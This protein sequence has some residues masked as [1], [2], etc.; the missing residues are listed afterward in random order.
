MHTHRQTYMHII[1]QEA[2]GYCIFKFL[3]MSKKVLSQ[4]YL[5]NT[6][7]SSTPRRF[8]A[9]ETEIRS[10]IVGFNRKKKHSLKIILLQFLS[11]V[12]VVSSWTMI[13]AS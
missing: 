12:G 11:C 5:R 2:F 3:L 6:Q 9:S 7:C 1:C 10:L 13:E 4:A 8:C